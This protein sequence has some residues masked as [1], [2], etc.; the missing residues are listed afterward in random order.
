MAAVTADGMSA[1]V[2]QPAAFPAA[3]AQP[4]TPEADAGLNPTCCTLAPLPQPA[5]KRARLAGGES[6]SENWGKPGSLS[7]LFLLDPAILFGR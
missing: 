6:A 1:A 7:L 3:V 2:S 5:R 4:S